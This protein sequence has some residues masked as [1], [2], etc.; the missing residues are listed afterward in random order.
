MSQDLK[1]NKCSNLLQG[2]PQWRRKVTTTGL[3][4]E[5]GIGSVLVLG[6][7]VPIAGDSDTGSSIGNFHDAHSDVRDILS[8]NFWKFSGIG[9]GSDILKAPMVKSGV[10]N[11]YVIALES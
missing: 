5:L 1:G 8:R 4:R 2:H 6:A 9:S 11:C 10:R 7:L 3:L